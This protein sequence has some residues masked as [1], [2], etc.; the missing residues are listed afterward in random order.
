[1]FEFYGRIDTQTTVWGEIYWNRR[2]ASAPTKAKPIQRF[3][4]EKW[5]SVQKQKTF[6]PHQR[7]QLTDIFQSFPIMMALL[8]DTSPFPQLKYWRDRSTF[9]LYAFHFCYL[10]PRII[11][12]GYC[13]AFTRHG[14]VI[15]ALF[16]CYTIN[17]IT[18]SLLCL[19]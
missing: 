8:D 17:V 6:A 5:A 12:F 4:N 18:F 13:L 7:P 10:K 9:C 3:S 2:K 14:W 16:T 11:F 19:L 1:M 15:F